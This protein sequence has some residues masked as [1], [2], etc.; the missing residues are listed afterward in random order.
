MTQR[1][2]HEDRLTLPMPPSANR[3]WRMD[4][5]G[6]MRLSAEARDYKSVVAVL[7]MR[8][9]VVLQGGPLAVT[10]EVYRAQKSGDLDNRI[11]PVLDALQGV[12]F[13]DD[14]QI[15]EIHAYRYDDKYNP[16]I[17][18]TVCPVG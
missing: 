2:K 18:V 13:I 4:K 3:L 12:M 11:K 14:K 9:G 16:R 5:R 7:A 6:F 10:L 15:I 17:E 8:D 1:S